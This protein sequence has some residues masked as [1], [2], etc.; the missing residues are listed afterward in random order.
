M[1][2][3]DGI[4]VEIEGGRLVRLLLSNNWLSEGSP[5]D[6]AKAISA[7]IQEAM[8][9]A[10][11]LDSAAPTPPRVRHLTQV[12][13]REHMAMHRDYMRRS[14]ELSRRVRDGEFVGQP[15][16]QD[17]EGAKVALRF[18]AGRFAEL[19]IDPRWAEAATANSIMEAV[20]EA[21]DGVDLAPEPPAAEEVVAL[22][23][24]RARIREFAQA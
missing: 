7:A 5:E 23:R 13:R 1:A 9:V 11:G 15:A 20:L 18:L 14:L 6:L 3:R 10:S 19:R 17:E 12:E 4:K 21:F 22:R 24:Q 8:P 2:L 16:P